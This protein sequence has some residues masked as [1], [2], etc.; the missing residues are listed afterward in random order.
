MAV[1]K[2]VPLDFELL[3]CIPNDLLVDLKSIPQVR[4]LVPIKTM[5]L[6]IQFTAAEIKEIEIEGPNMDVRI[7]GYNKK[8]HTNH[9]L[10]KQPQI[11]S[12]KD[13]AASSFYKAQYVQYVNFI[14][15]LLI[16]L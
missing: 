14:G 9:I 7:I 16:N 13:Q 5:E 10:F 1:N 3:S 2:T 6:E 8:E 12:I 11:D 4:S 15:F